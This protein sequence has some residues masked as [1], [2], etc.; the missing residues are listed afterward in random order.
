[1]RTNTRTIEPFFTKEAGKGSGLGLSQVV[2]MVQ[3]GRRRDAHQVCR[4][5]GTAIT[6]YFPAVHSAEAFDQADQTPEHVLVVDDQ[7][8]VLQITYA[9]I[10]PDTSQ[11]WK[12]STSAPAKHARRRAA[13]S[14]VMM[15][16]MNGIGIAARIEGHLVFR[17]FGSDARG[18]RR[19]LGRF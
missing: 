19:P 7:P 18:G 2:G 9:W 6:L 15:P 12:R 4:R 5:R 11:F 10:E 14:D 1:M 8:E 17:F 3:Q 16:G 13:F